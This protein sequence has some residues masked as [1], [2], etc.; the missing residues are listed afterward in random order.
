LGSQNALAAGGR[1]DTLVSDL[2]G[3]ETPAVGFAIGLDRV[4]EALESATASASSPEGK[5]VFDD[6]K[7]FVVVLGDRAASVGFKKLGELRQAGL[8]C[9][10]LLPDK[11][12]KAQMRAASSSGAR[13]AVILG[14]QELQEQSAMV[15]DL[16]A[17]SQ[18]KVPLESLISHLRNAV[19]AGK[20][21]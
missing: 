13:W 3:P 17:G 16:S 4:A 2:D 8:V 1:Y 19:P 14:D 18:E 12:M 20:A 21:P 7:A 5:P 6:G 11:S 15:K 10:G 9:P